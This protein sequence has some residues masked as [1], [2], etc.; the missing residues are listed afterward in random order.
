MPVF[1]LVSINQKAHCTD[2]ERG[3]KTVSDIQILFFLYLHQCGE[4]D[5]QFRNPVT[6]YKLLERAQGKKCC[7]WHQTLK[8]EVWSPDSQLIP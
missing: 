2:G 8:K 6:L 7:F 4:E 1:Y 5:I 3:I